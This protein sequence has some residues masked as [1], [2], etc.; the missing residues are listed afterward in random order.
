MLNKNN[1]VKKIMD[2]NGRIKKS[3]LC[4]FHSSDKTIV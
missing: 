3:V 4:Y 1:I 2:P